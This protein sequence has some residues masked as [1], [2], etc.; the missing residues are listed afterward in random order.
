VVARNFDQGG[1]WR[2]NGIDIADPQGTLIKAAA[3]GQVI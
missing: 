1:Q 2:H 3:D